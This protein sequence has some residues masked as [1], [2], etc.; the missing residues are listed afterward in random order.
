M[1]L[2]ERLRKNREESDIS[3]EQLADKL[4]VPLFLVDYLEEPE[5]DNPEL[6]KVLAEAMGITVKMFRGE[7]HRPTKEE[8]Q[9]TKARYKAIRSYVIDP[10]RC[11]NPDVARELFGDQP[12][13]LP[14][15]NLML[16]MATLALYNFCT[17]NYSSFALD[18]YL[19]RLHAPLLQRLEKQ[20]D[21]QGVSGEEREERLAAG[22]ANVFACESPENIAVLVFDNFAAELDERL[23]NGDTT[24]AEDVGMPFTWF[25]DKEMMRI[26]IHEP[27]GGVRDTIKLLD[28][29]KR[30]RVQEGA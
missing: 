17:N 26:E 7:A 21:A 12:L 27:D 3:R 6:E 19:F 1:P 18:K 11:E 16:Y 28:A 4:G 23:E 13:S 8:L 2:A 10:S 20:L 14:E 25:V 15:Q 30:K 9:D 22:R 29:S 5:S 24:F